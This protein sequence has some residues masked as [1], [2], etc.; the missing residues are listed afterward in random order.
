MQQQAAAGSSSS[1]SS[2]AVWL[3]SRRRG[4]RNPPSA[5]KAAPLQLQL[6]A[7]RRCCWHSTHASS[8]AARGGSSLGAVEIHTRL[9]RAWVC[10]AQPRARRMHA[11]M[12]AQHAHAPMHTL[13]H[14]GFA[15]AP[16]T[17]APV[18]PQT[19]YGEMLQYYLKMEPELFHTAVEDQLGR[20]KKEQVR[21]IAGLAAEVP[22]PAAAA[23]A[24]AVTAAPATAPAADHRVPRRPSTPATHSSEP[25]RAPR[26]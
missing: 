16:P 19:A 1:S 7:S 9:W 13:G 10:T 22:A 18:K 2:S 20:L 5:S 15:P 6:G 8:T 11:C 25:H 26:L 4:G 24:T 12:H 17:Q 14:M 3:R 23:A 21:G